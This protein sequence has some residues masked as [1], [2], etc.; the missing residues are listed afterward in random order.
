MAD[1]STKF[2]VASSLTAS[3]PSVENC[4]S[5]EGEEKDANF[6]NALDK[7]QL[8][9]ECRTLI[10]CE[11]YQAAQRLIRQIEAT[12]VDPP[13]IREEAN[14]EV[15]STSKEQFIEFLSIKAD[16]L[17]A[18][19]EYDELLPVLTTLSAHYAEDVV[20]SGEIQLRLGNMR[21]A[22]GHYSD[23]V[24][25][26]AHEME[27]SHTRVE[28]YRLAGE[29]DG[30][31][32]I[33]SEKKSSIT[34][35][36]QLHYL[37][38]LS[39]LAK[40]MLLVHDV[41]GAEEQLQMAKEVSEQL[42]NFPSNP[43]SKSTRQ[44]SERLKGV[45]F[46]R[47]EVMLVV[48]DMMSVKAGVMVVKGLWEKA[49]MVQSEVLQIRE[50]SGASDL[51]KADALCAVAESH[52]RMCNF[53]AAQ[54]LLDIA[55]SMRRDALSEHHHLVAEVHFLKG[56]LLLATGM[57]HQSIKAFE[58]ALSTMKW[59]ICGKEVESVD[60]A[61]KGD[62]HPR[63]AQLLQSL[64]DV[65]Y[66][67]GYISES[68]LHYDA[69]L[70]I[71]QS[72]CK[73]NGVEEGSCPDIAQSL[74]ALA[75]VHTGLGLFTDA[76]AYL[77]KSTDIFE[78]YQVNI[79]VDSLIETEQAMVWK[80]HLSVLLC[81][82]QECEELT[83]SVGER[84]CLLVGRK[85]IY[86]ADCLTTLG[87]YCRVRGRYADAAKMFKKAL[88]M[89][90]E[91]LGEHHPEIAEIQHYYAVC[92][93]ATGDY[94]AAGDMSTQSI[95]YFVHHFGKASVWFALSLYERSQL[96]RDVGDYDRARNGYIS[97]LKLI[98]QQIGEENFYFGKVLHDAGECFRL[99]DEI[100]LAS[101]ALRKALMVQKKLFGPSS[102]AICET[103]VT[104]LESS[105]D[106]FGTIEQ[107][108]KD[109]SE[110][111]CALIQVEQ[112]LGPQ[113]PYANYV[114]ANIG[115]CKNV[116]AVAY[117]EW[118]MYDKL[119]QLAGREH[120]TV[121]VLNDL[122]STE[123][124]QQFLGA[125]R[126]ELT[127]ARPLE[128]RSKSNKVPEVIF[129]KVSAENMLDIPDEVLDSLHLPGQV[130]IDTALNYFQKSSQ[131]ALSEYH[132]WVL[133]FGGYLV[134]DEDLL[135]SGGEGMSTSATDARSGHEPALARCEVEM[136]GDE[137]SS[138]LLQGAGPAQ[139]TQISAQNDNN[140]QNNGT[141]E[142]DKASTKATPLRRSIIRPQKQRSISEP[143]DD[144]VFAIKR[145]SDADFL[146]C[147]QASL[148]N[149]FEVELRDEKFNKPSDPVEK[150][151][152]VPIQREGSSIVDMRRESVKVK[153]MPVFDNPALRFRKYAERTT[154]RRRR[155]L[156]EGVVVGHAGL[157]TSFLQKLANMEVAKEYIST[158]LSP[159]ASPTR[160]QSSKARSLS[161]K[162]RRDVLRDRNGDVVMDTTEGK[163]LIL[164]E[165][166]KRGIPESPIPMQGK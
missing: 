29:M 40:S 165:M 8:I 59:S 11:R 93:R 133:R 125:D 166:S 112:N 130:A 33:L 100:Q 159:S 82:V 95:N 44:Q 56:K 50:K 15:E 127:P 49:R 30:E 21:L 31:S 143:V 2:V 79:D 147:I 66:R 118:R 6:S 161:P 22:G 52:L 124:H 152:H 164:K 149:E 150:T 148:L 102:I 80:I 138:A 98:K 35:D 156:P 20:E 18:L 45:D 91:M 42:L 72:L 89:K 23:A 73:A 3:F 84:I 74:Y 101:S 37:A 81:A 94:I 106:E 58:T 78:R 65:K 25:I 132:P 88:D 157:R 141:C 13:P 128:Y 163:Q 158:A 28:A 9:A 75:K 24:K 97:T 111:Q 32:Q 107:C 26:F 113:H 57:Y 151:V 48:A 55:Y 154:L 41:K 27:K 109:M 16:C 144:A 51:A 145:Q 110:F 119:V 34:K 62:A 83:N 38:T 135:G 136:V 122:L 36:P 90:L 87:N 116:L 68:R 71:Y 137:A 7:P 131:L 114:A 160:A 123:M 120:E 155:G 46:S 69:S 60:Q 5:T 1:D 153:N 134:D 121:R 4:A 53:L 142:D 77:K 39:C 64:G 43:T 76:F 108:E 54:P 117:M 86:V 146:S 10:V 17:F 85:H 61:M 162:N 105:L 129:K 14:S 12:T 99:A 103:Q 47:S 67:L 104:L 126:H 92:L 140:S 115:L 63:I 19:A 96:Q 70:T 139:V